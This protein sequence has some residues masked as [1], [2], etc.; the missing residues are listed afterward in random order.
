MHL[1]DSSLTISVN[2]VSE[3]IGLALVGA[4][5]KETYTELMDL[6]GSVKIKSPSTSQD[7]LENS[8]LSAATLAP[9]WGQLFTKSEGSVTQGSSTQ[10]SHSGCWCNS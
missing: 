10:R 3:L 4:M 6:L 1:N 8:S 5:T 7:G 9:N 2:T